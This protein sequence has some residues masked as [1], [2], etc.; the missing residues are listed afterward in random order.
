MA[1]HKLWLSKKPERNPL[2]RDKDRRQAL[3]LLDQ[4]GHDRFDRYSLDTDFV[5]DLEPDLLELFN[6]WAAERSF[7]PRN[8]AG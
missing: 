3:L 2:K 1:M 6:A 4:L 7:V 8:A 5:L